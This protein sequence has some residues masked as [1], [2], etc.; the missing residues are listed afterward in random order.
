MRNISARPSFSPAP[1]H[2]LK[3]ST[4]PV[5]PADDGEVPVVPPQAARKSA[6]ESPTATAPV[7]WPARLTNS[8]RVHFDFPIDAS[9][10]PP[11]RD[12]IETVTGVY[13]ALQYVSN[14]P[15]PTVRDM[16]HG[17]VAALR[18]PQTCQAGAGCSGRELWAANRQSHHQCGNRA[19]A[20]ARPSR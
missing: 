3:I 15:S 4:L 6:N 1:V 11:R 13:T 12:R 16:G 2:Q 19:H 18:A 14:T 20:W 17:P 9:L 5:S 10:I 8:R 7:V